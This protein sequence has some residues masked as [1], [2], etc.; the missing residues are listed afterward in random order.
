MLLEAGADPNIEC[1]GAGGAHCAQPLS[2]RTQHVA[3]P[4]YTPPTAGTHITLLFLN[5][6]PNTCSTII[7]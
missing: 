2:P 6:F 7:F 5:S 4:Q 3:A 1:G